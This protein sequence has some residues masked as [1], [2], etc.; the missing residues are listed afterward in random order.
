ML[1]V[2]QYVVNCILKFFLA[3]KMKHILIIGAGAA[4]LAAASRLIENGLSPTSVT[5]LEAQ[6][7]IGG[8]VNTT[9]HEGRNA[10]DFN[11]FLNNISLHIYLQ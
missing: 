9:T 2:F 7:R 11:L 1:N 5:I 6:N 10:A 4:G 8:R 3:I